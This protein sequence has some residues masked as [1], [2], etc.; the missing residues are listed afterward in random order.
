M[1][2]N[3]NAIK[4]P[5]KPNKNSVNEMTKGHRDPCINSVNTIKRTQ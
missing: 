2:N 3:R 1:K 4:G 5:N